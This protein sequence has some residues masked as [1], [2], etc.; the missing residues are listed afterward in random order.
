MDAQKQGVIYLDVETLSVQ[1]ALSVYNENDL[2][3]STIPSYTEELYKKGFRTIIG[4]IDYLLRLIPDTLDDDWFSDLHPF[5]HYES[6]YTSKEEYYRYTEDEAE[7]KKINDIDFNVDDQYRLLDEFCKIEKPQWNQRY[8]I[9]NS[10]FGKASA[11]S[12][13]FMMRYYKPKRIIE[14]GSGYSTAAML[15]VNEQYFDNKIHITSIEPYPE[16]LLKLMHMNDRIDLKQTFLQEVDL[17]LF[18]ELDDNDILFIDSS[19][20]C[21]HGGDV[22]Y[23]IFEIFPTLKSGIHIHI[24]DIFYP[25]CYPERWIKEGRAYNEMYLLRAFLMNN[26]DYKIELFTGNGHL[27]DKIG[28]EIPNEMRYL[29]SDSIWIRKA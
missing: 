1:E 23:E 25:F 29:G 17:G 14:I 27:F 28:K 26:Y 22:N 12:L 19:H 18:C 13:Y 9:D 15:D 4:D 5:A 16:R 20:V 21:K 6:P 24:H 11:D 3:I 10:W 7:A 2:I 8:S